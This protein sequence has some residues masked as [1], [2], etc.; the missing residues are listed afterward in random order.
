[1]K[2]IYNI[3]IILITSISVFSQSPNTG[4]VPSSVNDRSRID[5]SEQL[6]K[7]VNHFE[8]LMTDASRKTMFWDTS[9]YKEILNLGKVDSIAKSGDTTK[10]YDRN[11]NLVGLVLSGGNVKPTKYLSLFDT[12]CTSWNGGY[13][14]MCQDGVGATLTN[15]IIN[16]VTYTLNQ[17]LYDNSGNPLADYTALH[18]AVQNAITS[19]GYTSSVSGF[20][21]G[22]CYNVDFNLTSGCSSLV[23]DFNYF[24]GSNNQTTQGSST[25]NTSITQLDINTLIDTAQANCPSLTVAKLD[26]C[27]VSYLYMFNCSTGVWEVFKT[28]EIKTAGKTLFVDEV[29]GNNATAKKGCPTCAFKD[30]YEAGNSIQSNDADVVEVESGTYTF[31]DIGS[32]AMVQQSNINCFKNR[33]IALMNLQSGVTF[34]TNNKQRFIGDVGI[35]PITKIELTGD[36]NIINNSNGASVFA[37]NAIGESAKIN[38]N[39]HKGNSRLLKNNF[40]DISIKVKE[41]QS[42]A[43]FGCLILTSCYGSNISAEFNNLTWNGGNTAYPSHPLF[44]TE[45]NATYYP[46]YKYNKLNVSINNY[47]QAQRNGNF[48][49]DYISVVGHQLRD[50]INSFYINNFYQFNSDS[51]T[52]PYSITSNNHNTI[53]ELGVNAFSG[54]IFSNNKYYLDIDNCNTQNRILNFSGDYTVDSCTFNIKIDNFKGFLPLFQNFGNPTIS[55]STIII[56]GNYETNSGLPLIH[57]DNGTFINSKI[58]LKGKFSSTG[59]IIEV[60]GGSFDANSSIVLE[61]SFKTTSPSLPAI[62]INNSRLFLNNANITTSGGY[63]VDSPSPVNIIVK[64][65]SSSNVSTSSNVTQLGSGIYVDPNFNN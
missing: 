39:S 34:N 9:H 14:Y 10:F 28:P 40:K 32:G 27:N 17:P 21:D 44:S 50:N 60:T 26:S 7:S 20:D 16:G 1:M 47:T 18:T 31:G 19:A 61:G 22:G 15:I 13:A 64:P 55:N 29:Y 58:I 5:P 3:L 41:Y 54:A 63:S 35:S 38:L 6:R 57:I 4:I 52:N 65:G 48:Y 43:Q 8:V 46:Y 30:P 11:N 2:K 45:T 53:L 59:K 12:T 56:E 25:P 24:D 62:D 36:G 33:T 49:Y 23:I 37:L 51:V 42:S